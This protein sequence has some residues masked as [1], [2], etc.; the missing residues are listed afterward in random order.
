[1]GYLR[2]VEIIMM[3]GGS[4]EREIIWFIRQDELM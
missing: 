2:H 3:R 4:V 1:M